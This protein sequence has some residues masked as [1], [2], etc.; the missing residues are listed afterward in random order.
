MPSDTPKKPKK[1]RASKAVKGK[2]S[3]RVRKRAPKNNET[4]VWTEE[5]LEIFRRSFALGSTVADACSLANVSEG[6]YYY[7][8]RRGAEDNADEIDSDLAKFY[9]MVKS[10]QA[11]MVQ[12]NLAILRRA[13]QGHDT[14]VEKTVTKTDKN[15]HKIVEKTVT[16]KREYAW[17]AAAW[18][19]ER[20]RPEDFSR[21]IQDFT[22]KSASGN[23]SEEEKAKKLRDF[24]KESNEATDADE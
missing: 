6:T 4:A 1:R 22:G 8:M 9:R 19:L 24:L 14:T 7:R 23:D 21:R 15:G 10:A 2:A 17:Q 18:V 12:T 3:G 11:E 5:V 16:S 13:A 20:R